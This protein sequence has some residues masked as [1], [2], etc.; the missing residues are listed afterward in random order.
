[1]ISGDWTELKPY[2]VEWRADLICGWVLA[3]SCDTHDEARE[4]MKEQHEQHG[5]QVRVVTQHA[6]DAT[7]LGA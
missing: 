2:R 3:K 1:M 5:G 6:I 4:K 7:G